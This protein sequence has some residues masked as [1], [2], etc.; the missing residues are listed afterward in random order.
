MIL[1]RAR[2]VAAKLSQSRLGLWPVCVRIS[3][4]SP[5]ASRVR[6]G[7]M[8]PLT[9]APTQ[10]WPTSV[11]TE[12]G[13]V[14]RR[15]AA[16]QRLDLALRREDVD[17]LR[18]ELDPQVLQEL[19]R[20]ADFLLRF[21]QLAQP[22]KVLLVALGA[23]AAFLVLPVRR[24]ALLGDPVHLLGADLHLERQAALADDRRVQR[25]VAVRPRHRDEVLEPSRHRR[26]HLVDDAEHRVA[27]LDAA[28]DHAQREEVVDLIER[29]LLPLELLVDRP[30]ALD[31]AVD[32]HDRNLR[33]VELRLEP[34]AQLVDQPLGRLPLRLR[35]ACRS[36]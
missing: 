25:L 7:T 23:D 2:D 32:R 1:L 35:P 12:V 17:L 9:R 24:D 26:P 4:M 11:C 16:R 5:L 29:D 6:S 28:R 18:V 33:L 14:D 20:V 27:V 10:W 31:A 13:E 19:L 22:L 34:L 3:T 8:R 15:R 30:E 21:E 36:A